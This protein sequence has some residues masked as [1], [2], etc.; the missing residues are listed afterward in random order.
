MDGDLWLV[1]MENEHA[2]PSEFTRGLFLFTF[3]DISRI[4]NYILSYIFFFR[5]GTLHHVSS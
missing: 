5:R 3:R 4:M 2:T 1:R